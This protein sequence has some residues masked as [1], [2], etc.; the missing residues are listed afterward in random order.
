MESDDE[1]PQQREEAMK[2]LVPA[3]PEG[4]WG[5]TAPDGKGGVA[6][7]KF[8]DSLLPASMRP[9]IFEKQTYDGVESDSDTDDELAPEGSLGRHIG[10]MKWG[11]GAGQEAHIEELSDEGEEGDEE[12]KLDRE[13][14]KAL[15]LGDLDDE[16][17]QRVWGGDKKQLKDEGDVDMD[18]EQEEFLKFSRE[19]LGI[20]DAMWDSILAS[21][22][23]RGGEWDWNR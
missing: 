4:E 18:E 22:R 11:D 21:R 16:M 17:Q 15:Q 8:G 13:R 7:T 1:M 19:A 2:N 5:A 3:L 12:D 14:A 10:Q 23:E 9:P 6:A 20:D